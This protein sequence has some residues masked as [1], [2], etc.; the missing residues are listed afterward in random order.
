[1]NDVV[2]VFSEVISELRK[3]QEKHEPMH[4]A[5]EGLA[6]I[7][8]E[9]EELKHEVWKQRHDMQSMRQETLQL[10]AMTIRFLIDVCGKEENGRS[11]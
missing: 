11:K 1:M 10:A 4:S 9:F 7:W 8:E 6:V 5:H 2:A 3:A